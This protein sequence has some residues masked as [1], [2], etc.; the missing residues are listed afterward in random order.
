MK[1]NYTDTQL[2]A[3]IARMEAVPLSELSRI[4]RSEASLKHEDLAAVRSRLIAAARDGLPEPIQSHDIST[5]E[6]GHK[7]RTTASH[8]AKSER[9]WE[10]PHC[11]VIERRELKARAEKAEADLASL[12]EENAKM[13]AVITKWSQR[14]PQFSQ[15]RPLSEAGEVPEGCQR[16]YLW[17]EEKKGFWV[18]WWEFEEETSTHFADIRLPVPAEKPDP[19][20]ELKKAHAEGK[21]I[22]FKPHGCPWEDSEEPDFSAPIACYRIKPEPETFESHGKTWTRHTP[23]DPMPCD[24]SAMSTPI[25]GG[26]A[27]PFAV[28]QLQ[29]SYATPVQGMS[30]RDWF[31]GQAIGHL[32]AYSMQDGWARSGP[33]WRDGAASE[34]YKFADAMLEALEV[35]P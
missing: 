16:I 22:Q 9:E 24:G 13:E 11:L 27:F 6:K 12:K 29:S 18:P 26:P 21:V 34:A 32:A 2:Q 17:E 19:Y 20:A 15:L 3:A 25:N 4:W 5:C 28:Q 10:C 1:T 14:Q 30:L 33:E 35:K 7:F 31:A 23:G 8:P